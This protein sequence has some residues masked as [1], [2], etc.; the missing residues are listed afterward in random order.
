[1][2]AAAMYQL[3]DDR[4]SRRYRPRA[5]AQAWQLDLRLRHLPA[6]LPVERY[7]CGRAVPRSSRP[8]CPSC[9]RSTTTGFRRRLRQERRQ[10]RETPRAAAQRLRCARQQRQSRRGR[11]ADPRAGI[12]ARGDRARAR[13][14]GAR[15]AGRMRSA[16]RARSAH[17]ART[18]Y[19]SRPRNQGCARP[20]S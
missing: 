1:M 13:G 19:G 15:P 18:R 6:S 17:R 3:P 2:D 4:E 14:M 5:A 8:G 11:A 7:A 16:R 10:A 20:K 9:W 12:G